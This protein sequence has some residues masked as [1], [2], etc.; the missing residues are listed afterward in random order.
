MIV[1]EIVEELKPELKK[2]SI[3][4]VCVGHSFTSTMLDNGEVGISHTIAEGKVNGV[5]SL[6]GASAM[7]V[8]SKNLE[9]PLQRSLSVSI[10]TALNSVDGFQEGKIED[11]LDEGKTCVFG[12][13]PIFSRGD[14]VIYDF[15]NVENLAEKRRSFSSFKGDRCA[16]AIIYGSAIVNGSI[17][18]ILSMVSADNVAVTGVSSINAPHSLRS[19][20]VN[21]LGITKITDPRKGIR[22]VC[23]GGRSE[24]GAL[25]KSYFKRI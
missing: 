7:D 9:E 8:V 25:I 24:L 4:N 18:K 23:E 6:V 19:H 11:T 3:L 2:R 17:D 10:M 1:E 12:Y 21:I 14:Y 5:G 22:L 15:Y 13:S 16:N 20:G